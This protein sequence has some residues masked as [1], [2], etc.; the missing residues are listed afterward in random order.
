MDAL[1]QSLRNAFATHKTKDVAWRKRQLLQIEKLLDE[2]EKAICETMRK[3]INKA[4]QETVAFEIAVIKNS[5]AH[6]LNEMDDFLKPRPAKAPLKLK[7]KYSAYIQ[8]QP[9]GVVLII[10]AWN[11]PYQLCLV[12][13]VGAI[14]S[15][16]CALLKPSELSENSAK[17]MEQL[18]PKYL[19]NVIELKSLIRLSFIIFKIFSFKTCVKVLNGGVAETVELLKQR[20]D[21]IMYTG[22]T[23]IGKSIMQAAAQ[24]MTPVTLECGGKSP[25]YIDS[26]ADFESNC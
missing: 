11:Y 10:G 1:V 16:N 12:P 2:N 14:A 13:L 24:H 23:A 7:I 22:N 17:L 26:T 3:D 18:I 8:Y 21:Y 6:A 5:I 19:D 20:F 15:G 4:E 9:Y 25:V